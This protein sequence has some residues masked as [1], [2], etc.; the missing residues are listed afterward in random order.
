MKRQRVLLADDH[1]MVAEGLRSILA[2]EF[3][4][5]GIVSD[6]REL[7]VAARS[8]APDV[9]VLDISMPRLNGIEAA[10]QI[11]AANPRVK[12]IFLTM[13]SDATYAVRALEAG[14]SGFVLKHSAT[15]ELITAVRAALDGGTYVTPQVAGNLLGAA[16]QGTPSSGEVPTDIT[17]RQREILQLIAEGWSAK[18][19]AATLRISRRTAEYHK[20]RLMESLNLQTTAELI[21]YAIRTGVISV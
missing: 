8:L 18:E 4:V 11:H 9:I 20:A 12:L 5:V 2:L 17:P 16:R 3:D 7:V 19:I 14:A 15:S 1:Y 21:Q 6:G 13:H 10:R